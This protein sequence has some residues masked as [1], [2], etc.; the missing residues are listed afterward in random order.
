VE[1]L[2]PRLD[3]ST[4]RTDQVGYPSE[5][6]A[7]DGLA[8]DDREEHLHEIQPR[9]GGRD[10]NAAPDEKSD[11]RASQGMERHWGQAGAFSCRMTP[12]IHDDVIHPPA[13]AVDDP[14][15]IGRRILRR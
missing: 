3:E 10:L 14:A 15:V 8:S 9:A 13:F 4:D 1:A 11:A 2:V 12:F 6:A 7:A 5:G